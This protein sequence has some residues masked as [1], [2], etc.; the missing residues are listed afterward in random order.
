MFL[1][2]RRAAVIAAK[3][4]V[5]IFVYEKIP[6]TKDRVTCVRNEAFEALYRIMLPF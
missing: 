1:K 4:N 2:L 3:K 5:S 6:R